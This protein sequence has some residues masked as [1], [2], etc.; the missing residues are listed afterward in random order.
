MLHFPGTMVDWCHQAGV[1]PPGIRCSGNM[2]LTGNMFSNNWRHLNMTVTVTMIMTT[3]VI[4]EY[5][6]INYPFV[7]NENKILSLLYDL[8]CGCCWS[9]RSDPDKCKYKIYCYSS[10]PFLLS[11]PKRI[12]CTKRGSCIKHLSLCQWD[13]IINC[14]VSKIKMCKNEVFLNKILFGNLLNFKF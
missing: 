14:G 4:I 11:T 7:R 1:T 6:S 13:S 5:Q 2:T 10:Q 8:H 9:T 12:H 3:L